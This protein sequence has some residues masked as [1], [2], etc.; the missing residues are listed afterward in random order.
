MVASDG[1]VTNKYETIPELL[2]EIKLF[3]E[4]KQASLEIPMHDYFSL[5][6]SYTLLNEKDLFCNIPNDK[7]ICQQCLLKK[8]IGISQSFD[9]ET[10]R[11][12]WQ[13]IFNIANSIIFFSTT[14]ANIAKKVFSFH[15]EKIKIS[16][17]KPLTTWNGFKHN[18]PV[19]TPMTIG[20]IGTIAKHKGSQIIADLLPLLSE[21]ERIVIIG[22]LEEV[23]I[24][25]KKLIVHGAYEHN[26]LPELIKK[27]NITI[28]L[29][30]SIW[31]ETFNFTSQECV[32][33][34]LPTVAFNLGAQGE[35]IGKW[36][37]GLLAK[38]C[39][40]QSAYEALQLLDSRRKHY[41]ISENRNY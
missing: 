1:K 34:D 11:F 19:N 6:P 37:K 33:L 36:E 17:H 40:A 14:S 32:L 27:Y 4:K 16:P 15:E 39:T 38:N 30:P 9:I 26:E 25:S 41:I 10:W 22:E 29:I 5:C 24:K 23:S 2:K 8:N 7:Q 13:D 35:R 12:A 20:V 28:G 18:V 21:N 31:P 3:V